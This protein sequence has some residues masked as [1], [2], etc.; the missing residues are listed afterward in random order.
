M[1]TQAAATTGWRHIDDTLFVTT[2]ADAPLRGAKCPACSTVTFPAQDSCPRCGG[3]TMAEV[4]L[5]RQGTL[6][7]YTVQSFA[8]KSPF[9][10]TE[11][12]TPFG[13]GYVDLGDVIVESRLTVADADALTIGLPLRLTTIV[14]HLD[15]DG[16]EVR[17]FAFEPAGKAAS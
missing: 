17:T 13:V 6:W 2:D 14:N 16:T 1:T 9:R 7:S 4:T 15:A 8:P 11:P 12:F 5:P 3:S 10:T